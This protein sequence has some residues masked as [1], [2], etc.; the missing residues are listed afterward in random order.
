MA[1]STSAAGQRPRGRHFG[2]GLAC[3]LACVTALSLSSAPAQAAT[4]FRSSTTAE[5]VN[6]ATSLS[7]NVPAGVV[8]GDVML[9]TVDAEGAAAYTVP[10]GWSATGLYDGTSFIGRSG[11]Y[12]HVAGGSEPASYSWGLGTSRKAAGH[13][14]SYI[15]VDNPSPIQTSATGGASSGTS[16]TAPTITTAV[17][18]QLV[19]MD[20]GDGDTAQSTITPPG[21]TSERVEV[22]TSG[23]GSVVG[24]DVVDFRQ[25]AAGATGTKIFTLSSSAGW[26]TI[27]IGLD[28]NTTG[29]LAFD[30][31]PNTPVLSTVTLNGQAQ[32]T[33]AT[34]ANFTVEDTT[35][36]V[37]G[38]GSGWNVSV[39][40]D[41][42]VGKSA[43]FKQYCS[44]G[45]N[46]CGAD[47]ANSYVTGGQTL[48]AASLKINTTGA[49]WT[50]NGGSGTPSFPCGA[51]CSVDAASTTKIAS[52]AANN[53]RGAWGTSGFSGTS[54]QLSTPTTMRVL[55]A[56]ELYR[57]DLVWSLNSGP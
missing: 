46:P 3:G 34:M 4:F 29:A 21:G 36:A 7:I 40:G 1:P 50:T 45:A 44:N 24:H 17:A 25:V 42:A 49:S 51:G 11:V 19:V 26:G 12:F 15:G 33:N 27:T 16:A 13:I 22:Y 52:A 10:S 5:N 8:A 6:G 35:G 28:P 30:A 32:T 53:G 23:S 31:A 48:P 56:N 14:A 54:L 2:R 55:P 20:A 57:V 38:T 9:A 41:T 37:P 43:V 39:I 47:P 18:N